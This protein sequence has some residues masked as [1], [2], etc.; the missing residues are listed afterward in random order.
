MTTDLERVAR[1]I[2]AA[3]RS[4]T[5]WEKLPNKLGFLGTSKEL[6]MEQAR[7]AIEAIRVPSEAMRKAAWAGHWLS[8]NLEEGPMPEDSWTAM[9]DVILKGEG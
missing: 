3:D 5:P 1:A 7:A 9:C 4:G 6:R 2:Q 8:E